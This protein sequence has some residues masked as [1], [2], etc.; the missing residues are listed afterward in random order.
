MTSL[1]LTT[2]DAAMKQLYKDK[3]FREGTYKKRPLLGLFPKSEDF[4]GRNMPLVINYGNPQGV[5]ATFSTA[6]A[7]TTSAQFEDF[8]LTRVNEHSVATIDGDTLES[9]SNN[10][11]AF[12][13]AMKA[14]IDGAMKSLADRLES[15]IPLS[16]TGSLGQVS[17]GSTVSA[18]TITLANVNDI[19]NFEVGMTVV[20]SATDGGSLTTGSSTGEV[21]AAVNRRDGVLTATSAAWNTVISG[22]GTGDYISVKGDAKAAG[23]ANKVITGLSA[24]LPTTAPVVGGGDSF[25][26][27]DRSTD[28]RLYGNYYD[29]SSDLLEEALINGQSIAA[30]EGGAVD[31]ALLNHTKYRQLIK[32]LGSKTTF[33]NVPSRGKNGSEFARVSYSGVT[34]HGDEGDIDVIAANKIPSSAC[35]MLELETWKLCSIGPATKFNMPDGNRILRQAS[36][37]G[38]EA[39]LVFRGNLGCNAPWCNCRVGL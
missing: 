17:S 15:L 29:G 33:T 3:N 22:I 6:Q 10:S 28:S 13:T 16:G 23:S 2:A 35:Y 21:I 11:G 14:Q 4:Y 20:T 7:M 34:I 31:N 25:F 32:E 30:R 8:L 12:V 24:W 39:R 38:V 5:S 19:V 9:M 36:D 27:V 37:D 1:N 18:K 26:G